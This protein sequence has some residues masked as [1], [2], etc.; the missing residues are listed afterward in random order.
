MDYQNFTSFLSSHWE[1]FGDPHSGIAFYRVGLG[2]NPGQFDIHTKI[3]V[4]LRKGS[5]RICIKHLN[6]IYTLYYPLMRKDM[7]Q[8]HGRGMSVTIFYR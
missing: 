1:A 8:R 7:A 2:T 6:N 5:R 3:E 4:G